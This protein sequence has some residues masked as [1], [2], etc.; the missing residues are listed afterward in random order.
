MYTYIYVEC[1][2][3]R[4][5]HFEYRCQNGHKN[6]YIKISNKLNYKLLK[7]VLDGIYMEVRI[8]CNNNRNRA[9]SHSSLVCLM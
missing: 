2:Y 5:I 6:W 1:Q 9:I 3:I 8:E 7:F 4:S